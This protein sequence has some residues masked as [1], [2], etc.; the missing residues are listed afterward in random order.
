MGIQRNRL[1]QTIGGGFLGGFSMAYFDEPKGMMSNKHA[2]IMLCLLIFSCV[3][4]TNDGYVVVLLMEVL[5]D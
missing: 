3:I 4:R 1:W 2:D 5:F